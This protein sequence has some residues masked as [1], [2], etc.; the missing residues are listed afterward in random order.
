MTLPKAS[1]DPCAEVT[2]RIEGYAGRRIFHDVRLKHGFK[3]TERPTH[4]P[5]H[6]EFT[7]KPGEGPTVLVPTKNVP[8]ALVLPNPEPAGFLTGKPVGSPF[9]T[10]M[11]FRLISDGLNDTNEKR[12]ELGLPGK[13]VREVKI[14]YF[15]RFIAKVA[16]GIGVAACSVDGFSSSIT[17]IILKGEGDWHYWIGGTTEK[18]IEF[19]APSGN[20]LLHRFVAYGSEIDGK[21]Y[22]VVQL[23]LLCYMST[24]IY[25]AV[26]GELNLFGLARL[27][28]NT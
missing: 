11:F 13:F 14:D 9:D 26:V 28:S 2:K 20:P 3:I 4:L 8:G 19:E 27:N 10:Q 17:D 21:W 16:L 1:C 5:M 15:G 7:D 22:L 25:T 24:P 12:A 18:M 6:T 23:Q